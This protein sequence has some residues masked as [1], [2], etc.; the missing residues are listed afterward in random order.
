MAVN[1]HSPAIILGLL[2]VTAIAVWKRSSRSRLPLPPGPKPLLILGNLLDMPT[3]Q[4][5]P[6][7]RDMAAKYG[8]V[9]YMNT[10]GQPIVV[11]NSYEA[12][13]GVLE[14]RS[15]NSSSRP[16]GVMADLSSFIALEGRALW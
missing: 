9:M 15:A 14:G 10:L 11:L 6:S 1:V 16:Q 12:A 7:L 5:A 4:L 2:I 8:D 13:M 3:E